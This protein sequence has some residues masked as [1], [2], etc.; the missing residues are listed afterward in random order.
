MEPACTEAGKTLN[1]G[2]KPTTPTARDPMGKVIRSSSEVV[3]RRGL[4]KTLGRNKSCVDVG[5]T[6]VPMVR[7]NT[8]SSAARA[9]RGSL[10]MLANQLRLLEEEKAGAAR[11][12]CDKRFAGTDMSLYSFNLQP[13]LTSSPTGVVFALFCPCWLSRVFCRDHLCALGV[14]CNWHNKIEQK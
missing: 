5:E 2:V 8:G 11:V 10:S 3:P 12:R 7:S 13:Y 4:P 9:R 14:H 1:R 6:G